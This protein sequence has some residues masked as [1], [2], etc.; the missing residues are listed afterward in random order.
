LLILVWL[1]IASLCAKHLSWWIYYSRASGFI[2]AIKWK[3]LK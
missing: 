3:Q 2:H 1:P